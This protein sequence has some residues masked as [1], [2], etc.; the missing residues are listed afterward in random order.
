MNE[1]Q[2]TTGYWPQFSPCPGCG[3]CPVC[4]RGQIARPYYPY[5]PIWIVDNQPSI[6]WGI[7]VTVGAA[8]NTLPYIQTS[9]NMA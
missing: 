1:K 5:Q 8:G 7:N 2:S 4:G 3:R 9:Q 6:T